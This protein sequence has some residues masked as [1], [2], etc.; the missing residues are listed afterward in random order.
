MAWFAIYVLLQF[1]LVNLFVK[2]QDNFYLLRNWI[3]ILIE[4]GIIFNV[5]HILH[6]LWS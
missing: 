3:S 6:S 1:M 2:I 5:E 4:R